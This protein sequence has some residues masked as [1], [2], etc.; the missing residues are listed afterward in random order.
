MPHLLPGYPVFADVLRAGVGDAPAPSAWELLSGLMF[1]DLAINYFICSEAPHGNALAA[2]RK[3]QAESA[4]PNLK[5]GGPDL[6]PSRTYYL[7]GL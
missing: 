1:S 6:F 4:E 7:A 5:T 3:N 2:K